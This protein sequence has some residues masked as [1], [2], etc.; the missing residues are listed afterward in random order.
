MV[1]RIG[2]AALWFLAVGWGFNYASVITGMTPILGI[3]IAVAVAAFVAIDPLQLFWPMRVEPASSKV[4]RE[5]TAASRA[6][7]PQI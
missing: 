7:Q 1:K 3:A 5:A 2:S 4:A 6:M